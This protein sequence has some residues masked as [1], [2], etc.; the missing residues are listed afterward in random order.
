VLINDTTPNDV[1]FPKQYGRGRELEG[2]APSELAAAADTFPA[3]WLV[4]RSEWQARIQ[5][6]QTLGIGLKRLLTDLG[7]TVLN[8]QQT[9][10]CW[11]NAP[12]Y[13][14]MVARAIQ[15]QRPVRLSPASV[16]A[17]LT[18][19]RNVGGWGRDA[20]QRI[21]DVG[22]APQDVWPANT[23]SRSY[24]K[25]ATW[26][27]AAKYRVPRWIACEDR[28]LDQLVSLILRGH[29]VPVGYN[30][31]SHEVCAVDLGW[32]DGQPTLI[33]ANSWDVTWGDQGFG[34]IQG[35]RMVPDDAVCP[36][37][38]RAA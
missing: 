28:N 19:Y 32:R 22:V 7:I 8:Q 1:L 5:E 10:Y 35:S 23:I 2:R 37:V 38:T 15:G 27:A 21:S 18:N 6:R 9:N 33:I 12:T 24:D 26:A 30:W 14:T 34:E 17:P 13:A 11:A 25:P 4:P 16:A 20:L 3:T 31:W 29:P 36:I